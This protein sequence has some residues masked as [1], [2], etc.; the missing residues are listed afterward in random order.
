MARFKTRNFGRT[1]AAFREDF[2]IGKVLPNGLTLLGL[3]AGTTAIPF[4]FAGQWKA[5]V[6]AIVFAALFDALDGRVARLLHSDSAFGA[7][8]DSLADLVSFG[9]APGVLVYLWSLHV[10]QRAGWAVALIYCACC[11]I[12]LARFNVEAEARDPL[13]PQ[14][15]FFTGLPTPAAACLVLLPMLLGFQ[16]HSAAFAN[17]IFNAIVVGIMSLLMVSRIPTP[18]IKHI[19]VPRNLRSAIAAFVGL[20]LCV[21]FLWPWATMTAALLVY[22]A[23][24][25]MSA[26][27]HE[28][29]FDQD[30]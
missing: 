15:P 9:I 30:D 27:A 16:F 12:R 24:I 28:R 20:L 19:R 3:C 2:P 7:Q 25:P 22:L 23:T 29:H 26:A 10:A 1:A 11:A 5:A 17:P 13:E 18:S 4:A 21:A 8:L 14:D 6:T